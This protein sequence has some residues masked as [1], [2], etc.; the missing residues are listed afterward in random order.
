MN[1]NCVEIM[2]IYHRKTLIQQADRDEM[3]SIHI[4]VYKYDYDYDYGIYV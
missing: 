2:Q 1:G 3:K 4:P